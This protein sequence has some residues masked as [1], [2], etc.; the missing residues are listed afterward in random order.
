VRVDASQATEIAA[1]LRQS[2]VASFVTVH[3]MTVDGSYVAQ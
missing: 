3:T 2:D 1:M